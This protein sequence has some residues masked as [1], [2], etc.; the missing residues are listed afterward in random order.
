MDCRRLQSADSMPDSSVCFGTPGRTFFTIH[1]CR[2]AGS[3]TSH[4][5]TSEAHM[6]KLLKRNELIVQ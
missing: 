1:I 5:W 6:G 3:R 2:G 4:D